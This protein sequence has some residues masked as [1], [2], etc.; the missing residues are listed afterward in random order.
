MTNRISSAVYSDMTNQLSDY[1]VDPLDTEGATGY[2]ETTYQT[3]WMKWH[4][5]YRAIP[6]LQAVIDAK[7]RWTVGKGYKSS[8]KKIL[9][10]I[11]G[12]GKD[13]FN[14]ILYN[15]IRTYTIGGDFFAEIIRDNGGTLINLKPLN[16]GSIKIVTN[17]Y[18]MIVRY[19]QMMGTNKQTWRPEQMFHLAWNRVADEIHGISTIQ[20]CEDII[21]MRNESMTDMKTV[22]H[23]YVKPMIISKIDS[24]DPAEIAAFKTKMDR[25]VALGENMI[26]PKDAVELEHMSI[27]SNSTLDPLPWIQLLQ[28]FFIISEGVPEVILGSGKDNTEA[29]SKISYLAFQQMVEHNQLFL[30]EQIKAQLDIEIELEFPASID[31]AAT[32][33]GSSTTQTKSISSDE[34]KD[35]KINSWKKSETRPN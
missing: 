6:E 3:D 9:D 24:D 4:G 13:T 19:E 21:L 15:A 31:P 35:G 26:I 22:F 27:P 8:Q 18:G 34:N 25:A 32:G 30:E 29:S 14:S 17:A 20:K 7:A 16:P 28:K 23:R 2:G 12:F 10:Q 1:S 11:R 33:S 5:Y